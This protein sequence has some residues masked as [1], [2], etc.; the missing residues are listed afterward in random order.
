VPKKAHFAFRNYLFLQNSGNEGETI[1]FKNLQKFI[2]GK[3]VEVGVETI[4]WKFVEKVIF[5]NFL[6]IKK[7]LRLGLR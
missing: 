7:V 1:F 6:K 5:G 4:F 2:F 3:S